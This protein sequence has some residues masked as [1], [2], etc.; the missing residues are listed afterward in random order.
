MGEREIA[1][2]IA[3]HLRGHAD[4]TSAED[5]IEDTPTIVQAG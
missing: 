2:G 4:T 5:M 1:R 3:E